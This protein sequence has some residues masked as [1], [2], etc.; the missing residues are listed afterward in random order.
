MYLSLLFKS[1]FTKNG[2]FTKTIRIMK[3]LIVLLIA[4]CLQVSAKGYS[5][6]VTLKENNI[7]LQKVFEEIRKQTGCQFLYA[8][9]VLRTARKVS[10][11]IEKGSI[12]EVLDICFKDQQLSYIISGNTIIVKREVI[13]LRPD[14][15]PLTLSSLSSTAF[16]KKNDQFI[17]ANEI[18]EKLINNAIQITG[19]V[20][21]SSGDA[22]I[23]VSVTLK[24]TNTGTSTDSE[25]IYLITA[26]DGGGTLVF[27]YVGFVTKEIPINGRSQVDVT[28]EESVSSLDQVVVV[29]YATQKKASVVGAIST[30]SGETLEKRGGVSNLASALSG[31]IGGVTVMETTGEPGGPDPAILIRGQSTW[32]GSQPLILVDGI[33][34]KMN[35]INVSEVANISVLKD[36][37]ATAVFG[38]KGANGVILV[39]TKRG[40]VGKPVLAFSAHQ[41]I[42]NLSKLPTKLDAYAAKSWKNAAI[43]NEI[44]ANEVA[45]QYY[46]PYEELIRSKK[47]QIDPYTYL[48]P[49]VD[50]V[51]AATKDFAK[52][53]RIN[54]NVSGGTDFAKYFAS[55]GYSHDGDILASTY[56]GA[57]GY[58]PGFGYNRFNFRGNLD[59]NLTK[60]TTLSTNI[61]GYIGQQKSTNADFGG[62]GQTFGH[63]YRGLYELAPDAFPVKY[64]SGRYGK[65][66]RDINMNNPLAILNEGGVRY[67]NRRYIGTD[68]KLNQKLDFI[69]KGLSLAANV[70]WDNYVNSNGPS[71]VD[72]GNQGQVIYEFQNA[73]MLNAVTRQDSLDN[74]FIHTTAGATGIN[75]F[76]FI[77]RPWTIST[78]TVNNNSL[79]R[80]LFYQAGLNYARSFG[81]HDVTGLFLFNR[82]ENAS[83]SEFANYRE[84]WVGRVTYNYGSRYFAEINGAYNG[85][86]KFSSKYRFGF[87]P[88]AAVGWMISNEKFMEPFTTWLDKLKI[89]GSIGKVGSDNGIPRWGYVGSWEFPGT[90]VQRASTFYGANGTPLQYSPYLTYREGVIPNANIRWETATKKN[91]GFE[92]AAL[93]NMFTLDVDLFQDHRNDIF[94]TA[95]RRNIPNLFG[96]AA[97]P[98]NLG[99]TETKGYEI[100]L[101]FNKPSAN[102]IGYRIMLGMTKAKD[103][104]LKSEDPLLLPAYQK[105]VGFQIGQTKTQVTTSYLNNWD[106]VYAS[107]PIETNMAQRLPGDWDLLD[108]NSDGVVN[109]F[110]NVAYGSPDRPENT[111]NATVSLDYKNLSLLV[112]FFAVSNISFRTPYVTPALQR[113]TAVSSE[114]GDYWTPNNTDAFYKA[115]RLTTTSPTGQLGLYDGSYVR[116][117]TAEIAYRF[118]GKWIKNLGISSARVS[119]SGNN[120]IFWSDLPMDRETGSFDIQSG[121][122]MYR[123]FDFGVDISF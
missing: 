11:S 16:I 71:I 40:S 72:G 7:S 85:S 54:M 25:G 69:T 19:K 97:V 87:F 96:A 10:V 35:D 50:W 22:L 24:G 109:T 47:P 112:Q 86:E 111:Y 29:G 62:G 90:G 57:K 13:T 23:G 5:Q 117:K 30:I 14:A 92:L 78:E 28:L 51:D 94:M 106:E 88:S 59:F 83:G 3:L 64:P 39:T 9:E 58:D 61:S 48:Y 80:A 101:G 27:S 32:N 110:D 6:K 75:E 73:A 55:L 12:E 93:G 38:V 68:L 108:Y 20:V 4:A 100:A 105:V 49:N 84:D 66:P 122:P 89:R 1:D 34:R 95:S 82:R 31:Q 53:S 18:R 8:D 21:N 118:T 46:T 115:P 81:E 63:I 98:A 119:L 91:I 116:L 2:F 52:S 76:D 65:D 60:T 104:V 70:A 42:K 103:I 43:E 67:N 36:A 113:W 79:E 15:F 45:W 44:S 17:N 41:A 77:L 121:Y 37:S 26:S 99:E 74:L 33:E 56:N 123:Q 114:L 120:L 107:A 102:G